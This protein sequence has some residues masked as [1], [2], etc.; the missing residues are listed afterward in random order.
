LNATA[1]LWQEYEQS[2]RKAGVKAED[3]AKKRNEILN[4]LQDTFFVSSTMKT[5]N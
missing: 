1:K 2:A 5:Y 3:I 4:S